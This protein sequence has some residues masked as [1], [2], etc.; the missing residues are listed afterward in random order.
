MCRGDRPQLKE[1][2]N[3]YKATAGLSVHWILVGPSGRQ[4]RPRAGGVLR[5]YGRC[6][7]EPHP[8]FKTFVNTYF[9]TGVSPHPHNFE[10]TCAT[11]CLSTSCLRGSV[12]LRWLPRVAVQVLAAVSL[13]RARAVQATGATG[14]D[15]A[16]STK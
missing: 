5:A 7:P 10:Y 14:Q 9:V 13:R 2:L 16:R 15:C 8:A 12:R 3:N 6:I 11:S 1:L 4:A